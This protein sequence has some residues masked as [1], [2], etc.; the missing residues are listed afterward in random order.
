MATTDLP[1]P[2]SPTPPAP[3]TG[4]TPAVVPPPR[5][6]PARLAYWFY[7]VAAA[8]AVIGQTWVAV[9]H[10]P[11]SSSL[12]AV[13]RVAA[14]LPFAL[15]LEL[16]A[17]A[18]AAMADQ[19]MR[20]GERAYG[21]RLF[22]ATVAAVSVGIL[23]GGHWPDLYW[24]AGFG[25]LSAAAYLLWLLHAAARRRDAL[26]ATGKL[27]DTAPDYGLWRR[28]R[29]PLWTARAA[30]LARTGT[31]K[32]HGRW[33]PLGLHE[34]LEAARL[35]IRADKRRPAIA[36]AVEQ[37]IRADQS[38]PLM[39]EI[40]VRTLD[41]DRL[42]AGLADQIDYTAWTARLA[43]AITALPTARIEKQASWPNNGDSPTGS[44]TGSAP[45]KPDLAEDETS[46][47]RQP[48]VDLMRQIPI[49]QEQYRAW[50]TVWADLTN[51][52]DEPLDTIAARHKISRRQVERIRRAGQFSLL[53]WPIPPA[54]LM[55]TMLVDGYLT[56][57][58]L[59]VGRPQPPLADTNAGH[60]A[61]GSTSHGGVPPAAD[62]G[63]TPPT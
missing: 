46:D 36:K 51:H 32:P 12:P 8:G 10:I 60:T 59:T 34:S 37:V 25:L 6:S 49:Q 40:A 4:R 29:Y 33:R 18:L 50:Q 47:S 52:P 45:D 11:W 15:C 2:A 63:G 55:A 16:L 20:L 35:A 48:P 17:M 5:W 21:F 7:T 19:R 24:S 56:S 43:P 27:A 44:A 57:P 42:A 61:T 31:H 62:N 41:L 30:E 38:D 1:E 22:S 39:A 3:T 28:L 14:V 26:R 54:R 58:P 53:N 23:I 9:T 13:A